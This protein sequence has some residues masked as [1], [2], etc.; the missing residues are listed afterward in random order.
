MYDT[1][2]SLGVREYLSF[3]VLLIMMLVI[4]AATHYA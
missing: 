3:A 1:H 4:T 2:E